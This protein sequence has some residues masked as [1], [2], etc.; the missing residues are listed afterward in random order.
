MLS[1]VRVAPEP[2]DDRERYRVVLPTD[3]S[4]VGELVDVVVDCCFGGTEA[5][6]RARFRLCT[7]VAEAVANAML[8]GNENDPSRRVTV[9]IELHDDRVIISVSD[10]GEGFDPQALPDPT[11]P[12][13]I[14]LTT[15]RGLYMIHS[16]AD[17]VAFNDRGNTI[18]ITLSRC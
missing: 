5:S 3:V 7:V 17:H 10:E 12:D 16:L 11:A 4:Q 9:E 2:P 13:A 18:W 8:Y 15:G 14:E 6:S 1:A